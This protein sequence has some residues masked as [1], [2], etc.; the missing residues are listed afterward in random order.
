MIILVQID[1][2]PRLNPGVLRRY[3][4]RIAAGKNVK[5]QHKN[6]TPH[7]R[8][9]KTASDK[10]SRIVKK[11]DDDHPYNATENDESSED[12]EN[13][14][15]DARKVVVHGESVSHGLGCSR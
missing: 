5:N 11:G 10:L 15:F 3:L 12:V 14:I 6:K 4:I 2:S 13:D 9:N 8:Y 7:R 1:Y